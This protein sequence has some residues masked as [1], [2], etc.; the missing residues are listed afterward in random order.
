MLEAEELKMIDGFFT[1]VFAED[2]AT[3]R[4]WSKKCL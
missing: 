1:S 3:L 2:A 4:G